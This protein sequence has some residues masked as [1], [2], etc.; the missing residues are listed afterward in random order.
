MRWDAAGV[1][2]D[3]DSGPWAMGA[4]KARVLFFAEGATLA[5]VARPFLLAE[6]LDAQDFEVCLARP[7]DFAWLTATARFRVTDMWCLAGKVF[8]ERLDRGQPL[9][10]FQTL[11]RY[12]EDDLLLLEQ[13]KPDVVVGDFRLS[14]AVSARLRSI[15]YITLCDAY[16]SPECS[17]PAPLPVLP[18]TRFT[19]IPIAEALFRRVAPQAFRAHAEPMERLR[20][21]Y[22]QPSLGHDLR[23]CYSDADLR[24]FAN[25]APLFPEVKGN[26]QAQF[27][28][29]IAWSPPAKEAERFEGGGPLVYVTMGSSGKVDALHSLIP[30]LCDAGLQVVIATAGKTLPPGLASDT[31]RVFDYVSGEAMCK[32]AQLVVCNGGSP[33]T[34]QALLAGVPVLGIAQNMDQFF[35]MGAI[36]RF[37]AGILV[38]ADRASQAVLKSSVIKLLNQAS[39]RARALKLA[40]Q[41]GLV[42]PCGQVLEREVNRLLSQRAQSLGGAS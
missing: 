26:D 18:F 8:G 9:Y 24:L 22:G 29:P 37:G 32:R 2:P 17:L 14:L 6:Q 12:V 7:A 35:N 13:F 1:Y 30:I 34:N 39:Y 16:W 31:V 42:E 33:T 11:Q 15:P 21:H 41:A 23:S 20:R 38:R 28:G 25:I 27:I 10:D 19:P 3:L 36:E 4:V 40:E 5:H